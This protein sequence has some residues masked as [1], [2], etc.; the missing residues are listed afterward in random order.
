MARPRFYKDDAVGLLQSLP[1][2]ARLKI[3]VIDGPGPSHEATFQLPD[4]MPS[5]KKLDGMQVGA[6]SKQSDVGEALEPRLANQ[7]S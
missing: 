6:S 2:G 3:S 4:W 5:G 1:D 7:P